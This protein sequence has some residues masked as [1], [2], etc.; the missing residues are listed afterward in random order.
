MI[1]IHVLETEIDLTK[2]IYIKNK[3]YQ[4]Y[5]HTLEN[6][7]RFTWGEIKKDILRLNEALS[8]ANNTEEL[9]TAINTLLQQAPGDHYYINESHSGSLKTLIEKCEIKIDE[10]NK[11]ELDRINKIFK[12]LNTNIIYYKLIKHLY[13]KL[14]KFVYFNNYIKVK[15][16]IH[17]ER[18]AN[19]QENN[20]LDDKYYDYG[21]ISLLKFL[22]YSARELANLGKTNENQ[23][24]LETYNNSLD[25]RF[26]RLNAASINLSKSIQDIWNPNNQK[27]EASNLEISADGQSLK[28]VVT[29]QL[30]AKVELD[31]RSEGFQWMVS[32][33]IVFESQADNDYK[34]CI[35]LLDEPATSL[36]A[37]KQKEFIKTISKLAAK[38]QT[39]YTTHSP[40]MISQDELDLVGFVAQTYL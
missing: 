13:E 18:L 38:N 24:D 28:V 37:L 30:G 32:F 5:N 39:I 20:Q 7:N 29:D 15:P 8:L 40:F 33:F 1:S 35:L 10:D 31:Q 2:I 19:R 17:L 16:L 25:D 11:K 12:V 21:N 9:I 36:H 14:P 23:T 34:N 26:Y 4:G 27:D 6:I 3:F 22:G